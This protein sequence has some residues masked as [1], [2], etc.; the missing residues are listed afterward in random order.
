MFHSGIWLVS[1][2]ST[3][4]NT[5]PAAQTDAGVTLQ[6]GMY[7]DDFSDDVDSIW[8]TGRDENSEFKFSHGKYIIR[9]MTDSLTYHATVKFDL[10]IDR[11]FSV[12]ASATQWGKDHDDAY[13][14][15]FCGNTES[16][17]HSHT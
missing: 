1:E 4:A 16:D 7:Y 15:N 3:V 9:G 2:I 13:G 17:A 10:N 11:N 14:I 12:S 6:N 5:A 8:E